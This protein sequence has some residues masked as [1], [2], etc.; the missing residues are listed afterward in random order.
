MSY[1]DYAFYRN[2]FLGT[3]IS[4]DAF[5]HLALM[6]SHY[7]DYLTVGKA[8][9]YDKGDEVK[10]ACCAVAEAF[11]VSESSRDSS[12]KRSESV[13]SWSAAYYSYDE[14]GAGVD[15]RIHATARRYLVGTG[16]L[17]RGRCF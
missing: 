6:A 12:G 17:Y 13:G 4:E 15:A 2:E 3:Y 14:I 9:K 1:A 10:M 16:L 7:L 5:D 11:A 8:K